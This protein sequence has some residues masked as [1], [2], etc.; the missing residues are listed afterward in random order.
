MFSATELH[1]GALIPPV[2]PLMTAVA[3]VNVTDPKFAT[4]AMLPPTVGASTIQ[5]ALLR[6]G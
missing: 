3:L 4:F 5:S 1:P 6:W 2:T